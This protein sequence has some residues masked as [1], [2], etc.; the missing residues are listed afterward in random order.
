MNNSV[1]Y[2]VLIYT[3]KVLLYH[4]IQSFISEDKNF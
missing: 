3:D 4:G 1:E 2:N